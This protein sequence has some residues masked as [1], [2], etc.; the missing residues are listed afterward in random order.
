MDGPVPIV[1]PF[2]STGLISIEVVLD[3]LL[4]DD[5]LAND[6]NCPE[7]NADKLLDPHNQLEEFNVSPLGPVAP[8]NPLFT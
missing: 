4:V 1:F 2:L 8:C 7:L 5:P 6:V 3:K